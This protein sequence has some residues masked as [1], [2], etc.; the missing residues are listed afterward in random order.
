VG[1]GEGEVWV[2]SPVKDAGLVG[3]DGCKVIYEAGVV[4]GEK[5]LDFDGKKVQ[6]VGKVGDVAESSRVH[7]K[8]TTNYHV[9]NS[10][11]L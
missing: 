6:T 9:F 3:D 4:D 10:L 1:E 7:Y 8:L 11:E 5:M 2:D